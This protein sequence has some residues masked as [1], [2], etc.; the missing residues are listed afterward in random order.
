[1]GELRASLSGELARSSTALATAAQSLHGSVEALAPP[2]GALTSELGP[3]LGAL[4]AEVALL[5]ARA[6]SPDEPNAI[7]DELVRLGEDVERLV[8]SRAPEANVPHEAES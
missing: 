8:A 4:T 6:E 2:L 1:V 7:L 3:Q 5:A